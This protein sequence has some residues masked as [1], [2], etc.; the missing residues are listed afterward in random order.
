MLRFESPVCLCTTELQDRVYIMCIQS[1]MSH[2]PPPSVR[3]Y[4]QLTSLSLI[5]PPG[6][7]FSHTIMFP[8]T[9]QILLVRELNAL[10]PAVLSSVD[11][12]QTSCTWRNATHTLTHPVTPQ[13]FWQRVLVT[14]QRSSSPA[15]LFIAALCFKRP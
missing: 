14:C 3:R 10:F 11:H 6:I 1:S 9:R 8:V 12:I 15:P 7:T 4:P 2:T 13:S 5:A